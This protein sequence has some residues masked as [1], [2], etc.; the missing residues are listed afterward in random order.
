MET[1]HKY[2]Q[3][4]LLNLSHCRTVSNGSEVFSSIMEQDE[5]L[6]LL[7]MLSW[8]SSSQQRDPRKTLEKPR[9]PRKTEP[10]LL[11]I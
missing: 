6:T 5:T 3:L 8:C 1:E 4:H 7:S 11:R 10:M 2:N 9:N